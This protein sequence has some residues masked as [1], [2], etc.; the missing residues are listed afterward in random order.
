MAYAFNDD[1]SKYDLDWIIDMIFKVSEAYAVF[2][3]SDSSLTFFRD[4]AGKYTNRQ[5]VDTK[6]YYT[7]IENT[8][9]LPVSDLPWIDQKENISKVIFNDVVRPLSCAL[10]F[11]SMS[12]LVGIDNLDLLDTSKTINMS[13]MFDGC[14][15]LT[16]L[17]L[18]NFDTSNVTDMS[19]MFNGCSNLTATLIIMNMLD[20]LATRR[21]MCAHTAEDSGLLTLKYK[22]PVT[23]ADIDTIVSEAALE[24]GNVV[25]GGQA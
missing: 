3:S 14:T 16:Q 7:G 25:N 6:I 18:S 11:Y 17:D 15:N 24:Y 12:N 20:T 21:K 2:D 19:Y 23:S 4:A 10:W 13:Y 9:I 5:A 1:K 22:A 8:P